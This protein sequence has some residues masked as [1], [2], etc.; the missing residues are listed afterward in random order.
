MVANLELDTNFT[1]RLDKQTVEFLYALRDDEQVNLSAWIRDAIRK[2]AGL[3][4]AKPRKR[5]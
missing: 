1:L 2:K 4:K 5:T 3:D